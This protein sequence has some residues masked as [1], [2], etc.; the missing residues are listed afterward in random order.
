MCS[1]NG[2]VLRMADVSN[3]EREEVVSLKATYLKGAGLGKRNGLEPSGRISAFLQLTF[4]CRK[5]TN[6]SITSSIDIKL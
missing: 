2:R 3:N 6:Q 4:W 1:V 5:P